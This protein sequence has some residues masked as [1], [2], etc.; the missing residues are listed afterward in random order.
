MKPV[1][2]EKL[3]PAAGFLDRLSGGASLDELEMLLRSIDVSREDLGAS[4]GFSEGGYQRNR[5]GFSENYE[6]VVVCWRNGQG[7]H[8]H[9]HTGSA[10]AFKII[11]G[12]AT[13]TGFRVVETEDGEGR[14]VEPTLSRD[15]PVGTVCVAADQEIHQVVNRQGEGHDLVTLHIYSPMLNMTTYK[16][17]PYVRQAGGGSGRFVEVHSNGRTV[18]AGASPG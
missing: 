11:E 8:I 17:A 5:I 14:F 13:E 7:S 6:M 1:I 18:I 12:V 3:R 16:L 2:P 10:C 4:C 9:D 15:Y